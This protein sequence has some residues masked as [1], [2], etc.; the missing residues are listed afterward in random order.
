MKATPKRRPQEKANL[1]K[2][3]I[4]FEKNSVQVS[5]QKPKRSEYGGHERR[6]GRPQTK[7]DMTARL[8]HK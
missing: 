7:F 5:S 2:A 1:K 3:K 6:P 4:P 8:G